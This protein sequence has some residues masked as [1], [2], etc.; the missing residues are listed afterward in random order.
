M[1]KLLLRL[2]SFH[3]VEELLS[4]WFM[5]MSQQQGCVSSEDRVL[6]HLIDARDIKMPLHQE[7]QGLDD[8]HVLG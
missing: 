8:L 1:F 4:C 7:D 2:H 3:H 6:D 5:G